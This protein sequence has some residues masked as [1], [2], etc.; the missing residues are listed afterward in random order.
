[1]CDVGVCG[2]ERLGYGWRGAAEEEDSA[3]NRVSERPAED[4]LA[5]SNGL[6]SVGEVRGAQ[7]ES[8]FGVAVDDLVEEEVMHGDAFGCGWLTVRA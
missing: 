1:M 3:V 4:E 5:P 2:G 7:W 8:S 6:A